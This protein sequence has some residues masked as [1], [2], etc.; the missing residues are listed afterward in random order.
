MTR[1][2]VTGAA[3]FIDSNIVNGGLN[4]CGI[5]NIIAV[6][7]LTQGDKFSNLVDLRI[8]Y[9]QAD[10]TTLRDAGCEHTLADVVTGVAKYMQLSKT[11]PKN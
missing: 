5:D 11:G 7:D 8:D 10:L 3:G 2:V 6:A 9:T 1:I 4:A